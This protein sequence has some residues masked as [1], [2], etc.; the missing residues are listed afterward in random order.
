M[1]E[2]DYMKP[3]EVSDELLAAYIDGN[4]TYDEKSFIEENLKG[5]E[6]LMEIIEIGSELTELSNLNMEIIDS[7]QV[8]PDDIFSLAADNLV[9]DN[10]LEHE[11][12]Y[13]DID[14]IENITEDSMMSILDETESPDDSFDGINESFD[15]EM[16]TFETDDL[17][18]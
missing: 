15:S 9:F 6:E 3:D 14:T 18:F 11:S 2:L 7:N 13:E 12:G 8:L 5:N 17:N 16:D 10:V 1:I 4:V